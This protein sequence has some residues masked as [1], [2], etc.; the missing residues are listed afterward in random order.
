MMINK[1]ESI[2]LIGIVGIF[3]VGAAFC[4]NHVN[5]KAYSQGFD[6][7]SKNIVREFGR[8]DDFSTISLESAKK[9]TTVPDI[10][11]SIASHTSLTPND[12]F[13]MAISA[14]RSFCESWIK[15]Y[16]EFS[17][18]TINGKIFSRAKTIE[19]AKEM[20]HECR[21]GLNEIS[22]TYTRPAS[23]SIPSP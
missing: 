4:F 10:V 21:P 15:N 17:E 8:K 14:S 11:L 16:S 1:L 5:A 2:M 20:T 7:T 13:V 6:R 18:T 9:F 12:G 3:T 23:V 22:F 19:Q